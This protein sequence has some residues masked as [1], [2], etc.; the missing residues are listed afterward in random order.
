VIR[1]ADDSTWR[2]EASL[3]YT[4]FARIF[5]ARF[6]DLQF[7]ME[8]AEMRGLSESAPVPCIRVHRMQLALAY[9][10]IPSDQM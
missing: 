8:Q 9:F 5:R 2:H 4:V 3:P 6:F 10:V 1:E 7:E